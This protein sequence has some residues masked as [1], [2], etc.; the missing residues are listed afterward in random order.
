MEPPLLAAKELFLRFLDKLA[1][2]SPRKKDGIDLSHFFPQEHARG[3]HIPPTTRR[4]VH[5]GVVLQEHL[6]TVRA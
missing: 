4:Q 1:R 3:V 5:F 2:S 6:R